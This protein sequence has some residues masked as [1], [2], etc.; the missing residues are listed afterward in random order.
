MGLIRDHPTMPTTYMINRL[1][2]HVQRIQFPSGDRNPQRVMTQCSAEGVHKR[3][4]RYPHIKQIH[5]RIKGGYRPR[6]QKE[7]KCA[8]RT[9]RI[10]FWRRSR[11]G[12]TDS[13]TGTTAGGTMGGAVAAATASGE[14]ARAR[15]RVSLASVFFCSRTFFWSMT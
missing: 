10:W 3:W 11:S 7:A 14:A 1:L 15:I 4:A 13:M 12:S 8:C 2:I 5:H 9:A 6:R